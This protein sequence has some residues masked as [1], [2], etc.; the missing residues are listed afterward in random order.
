MI[1]TL[2]V[3]SNRITISFTDGVY[4]GINDDE[5]AVGLVTGMQWHVNDLLI[6]INRARAPYARVR[7]KELVVQLEDGRTFVVGIAPTGALKNVSEPDQIQMLLNW[8]E[9]Y[10]G[11]GQVPLQS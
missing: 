4:A 1:G 8:I 11:L 5:K 9:I 7:E 6:W 2:H 3:I 10:L